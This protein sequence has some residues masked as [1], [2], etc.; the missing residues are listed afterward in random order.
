MLLSTKAIVIHTFPYSESSLMLKAYTEKI[1]YTTFLL[2]GFKRN[3]KQKI[4]LHPLALVEITCVA[5]EKTTLNQARNISLLKPYSNIL[6][7]PIKSGLAMFIAEFLGHAIRDDQEGE[8]HFFTWL[9]QAIDHLENKDSLANFHLW[10][11]LSLTDHLGF[12]PQGKRSNE[13]PL[14]NIIEG[15]FLKEGSS[16]ISCSETE[17]ILLDKLMTNKMDELLLL[18]FSK[19][20]RKQILALLHEY[21]QVHL[22]KEFSLKSLDVLS[23]LY[24]D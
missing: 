13:T 17:S 3:K 1:G 2:K 4:N 6:T 20:E 9:T 11:L 23:Q 24:T 19:E 7:N 18:R 16:A 5:K 21:F 12:L 14:F 15:S 10:F 8:S 22:D